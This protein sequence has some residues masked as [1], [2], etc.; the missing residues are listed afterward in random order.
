[1]HWQRLDRDNSIK[2]IDSVKSEAN[3]G[4]F[5][6]GTSEVKR[7]RT[8]YYQDYF[9]YKVTNFA[10][11]PSFSFQYLSDGTFFH[12]LD[13]T[14]EPIYTVNDKGALTLT[15][16]TIMAYLQFFFE[17]VGDEDGD[18][19]LI[20]NPHDMPLLDSLDPDAYNAVFAQYTAPEVKHNAESNSYV[21]NA[22]LY[23]ESQMVRAEIHISGRGRVKIADQKMIVQQM[24]GA[25]QAESVF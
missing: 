4:L 7:A 14:E 13:G 10:S 15:P 19:I 5:S 12:Y 23:K 11:L 18:I 20:N 3:A 1:M 25:G 2:V 8:V 17:Q 16:A 6:A 22:D 9:I 24:I 21:V